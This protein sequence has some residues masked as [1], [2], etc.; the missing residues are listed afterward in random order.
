MSL[1]R[2]SL[3]I[4]LL[5]ALA[6]TPLAGQ[7]RLPSIA[8]KTRGMEKQDGFLPLYW[9]PAAGRLWLE[10]PALD[11]ELIYSVSLPWG[12]GSNDLGL[13]R[14]QLGGER[15]IRFERVGPKVLMV[16][17]NYAFRATT[18]D[19][20][21]RRAVE[22][23][24][25]RSVLWGFTVAA[26]SGDHVLVDATDFALRDAHDVIGT[27][28][29]ADQGTYKLDPSRSAVYPPHTKAF[30][31][32]SE[33]EAT[34]TFVGDSPG[35]WVRD[36]TPTPTAITVRE[37]QSFIALPEPGYRP[38]RNDPRSGFIGISYADYATPIDAPLVQ[39]FI[40][41]YRLEKKDPTA[42]VSEPVRPIVYY[43]DRGVPEPIRSALLEGAGW[44]SQAFEAAGFRNAFRVELLPEGADPM[45]VRY[46]VIQW[47]H[48]YTRGWSYGSF[49]TDPRTGEILKGHVLLGSLRV[50]QDYL[51]AVGLLSP[52][53]GTNDRSAEAERMALARLRQ[54]AAH[55]VGHTLGLEHNY[56]ASSQ[57]RASVMDYPHPLETLRPDG[58]IDLSNAY[59]TGI[60]AWDKVA[61]AYGYQEIPPGA[62][63]AAALDS[64]LRAGRE[65]GVWLL[66]D[67]DA[68]PAGSVHPRTHL[69][70]NGIDPAQELDRVMRLR[71]AAL[72][73]FGES[74][75]RRGVPLATLEDV[76]V[77]L[78]LHHRYQTE[79]AVKVI[80][81]QYYTYALRGDGQEPL[82]SVP[83]AEQLEALRSVLATLDP[84][85]LAL[86]RSVLALVPPR[87]NG[88]PEHRELFQRNTG[89]A[90]DAISPA[91]GA[92][93]LAVGLL[94][95]PVRAARL[96]EQH[97]LDPSLPGLGEVIDR[98]IAATFGN[99]PPSPYQA[100][101][102]RS[103]QR[104]V[105]DR[106]LGLAG[107]APM[108]QVRALATWKLREL[109]ARLR[110]SGSQGSV[111][112]RA[113]AS[114]LAEDIG[115][116][117]ERRHDPAAL[118]PPPVNPPGA[119]IGAADE[120]E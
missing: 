68:R 109:R 78:Y 69:W 25:A 99:P 105:T 31:R 73:R 49:I 12:V 24:F 40:T 44:W 26:E 14:S 90:F 104:V 27:L 21:E 50:R 67:Q 1:A 100:E 35:T 60:G 112:A 56:I 113:H 34:L 103:E 18:D 95:H 8:E 107:G 85:E 66:T 45:D 7:E 47:V 84:A 6:G 62:D 98:L 42:A 81:G 93:D 76:L 46:N 28:K 119:P 71:H 110:R 17:P 58:S 43:L 63:E 97:D 41:R 33:I 48:R 15:V 4:T 108:A 23:S 75:I 72:Q 79:A 5:A 120:P 102:R 89:L 88:F 13:D 52:Y 51:I 30:P 65:Q 57:G 2:V 74:A 20:A 94:L 38:R 101:I 54:L 116:F 117:L 37:R 77:P 16:Q 59:A 111:E 92:A 19:P 96:V 115:R 106:L 70:D 61:I 53:R 39:Q 86:P 11:Q 87:P 55:E 29:R 3:G 118:A 9:D 114:L 64:T 22:E 91:T 83:A 36:V 80:G 10:I 32:N 82:R